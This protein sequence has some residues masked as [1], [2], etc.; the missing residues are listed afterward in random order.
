MLLQPTGL[1]KY[2]VLFHFI[3]ARRLIAREF[4][5]C[6]SV[7]R[8]QLDDAKSRLHFRAEPT[9]IPL[10]YTKRMPVAVPTEFAILAENCETTNV[11]RDGGHVMDKEQLEKNQ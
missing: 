11:K 2:K 6:S 3:S 10:T 8:Y 1:N 4:K 9:N 7:L 5:F